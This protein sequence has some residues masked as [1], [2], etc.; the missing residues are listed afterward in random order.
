MG[1]VA[2]ERAALTAQVLDVME[3]GNFEFSEKY[4]AEFMCFDIFARRNVLLLLLKVLTNIDSLSEGHA[5]EIISIGNMLCASPLMVGTR[6][7]NMEMEDGVVYERY[8]IPAI[9]VDTFEN[10]MLEDALPLTFSARGGYYVKIDG[11]L[12]KKIRTEGGISLG[13]VAENIGVSRRSVCKYE[14][15]DKCMTFKTA[16]RLEDFLDESIVR[17][18]NIFFIPKACEFTGGFRGEF[19]RNA[20]EMLRD[21]GF[22]VYPIKKAPFNALTK[23]DEEGVMITKFLR[24]RFSSARIFDNARILKSISDTVKAEVFFVMDTNTKFKECIHGIPAVKKEELE[25][26]DDSD[27]LIDV[28]KSRKVGAF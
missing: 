1:N 13:D 7:R 8:N 27:E 11:S 20:F 6:T 12:L 5:R 23:D 4:P 26:I 19:E 22:D 21:L 17:P 2:N 28:I 18:I 24:L 9:T 3:R 16:L 14:N 25:K 15:E 10:V